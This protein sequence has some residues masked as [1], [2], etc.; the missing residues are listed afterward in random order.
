M[1]QVLVPGGALDVSGALSQF[2]SGNG[3]RR[4]LAAIGEG[5]LFEFPP[6]QGATPSP[7]KHLITVQIDPIWFAQYGNLWKSPLGRLVGI[8]YMDTDSGIT[9]SAQAHYADIDVIG[10]AQVFKT[11]MGT[12]NR[13]VPLV[14]HFQAQGISGLNM[15]ETLKNEVI[16]PAKWFDALNF[17]IDNNGVSL[18]PPPV[19]LTIGQL[20]VMR[21]IVAPVVKWNYPVDP[22]TMLP[23]SCDV[24]CTFIAVDE[25]LGD[26]NFDG[27]DRFLSQFLSGVDGTETAFSTTAN[28]A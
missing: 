18:A 1:A 14:F 12:A 28:Q 2:L 11:Y 25:T 3:T 4:P 16:N 7:L 6:G 5:D 23:L 19:I 9:E 20:L 17:P 24:E 27:P 8:T 15:T 10:R 22:T 13:E 21:A 26:Y